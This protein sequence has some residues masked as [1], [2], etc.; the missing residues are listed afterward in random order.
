MNHDD[1]DTPRLRRLIEVGSGLVGNLDLESLL[2][3]I[4][5][6][7]REVT[8][9]RYAALGI[10]G[11]DRQGLDRFITSGIEDDLRERIGSLPRGR[12]VLGV[13][14]ADPRPLRLS[15]VADHPASFGFPEH[16][17]QMTSFL[18]VPIVI[19]GEVYGN[20]Y[21]TDRQAGDFD[22][23]DEASATTLAAWAAIAIANAESVREGRLRTTLEA[24]DR[25]RRRWARELHD[26][27]LQG[28]GGLQVLLSSAARKGDRDSLES[29]TRAA[30]EQISVEIANLRG[31]ISELR[32]A[33]LD[34]IG[35]EPALESLAGRTG[36]TTDFEVELDLS[37]G[38]ARGQ[39]L[40]AELE[41][42]VYRLVQEALTNVIKHA[43]ASHVWVRVA[44]QGKMLELSV[45]DDGVGFEPGTTNGGLGLTGMRERVTLAGGELD[46]YT[47]P[48]S[49]TSVRALLPFSGS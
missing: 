15:R 44:R 28:L 49:G 38:L 7:A 1:L 23:S 36:L 18:G 26:E 30:V 2:L 24:S 31:L 10:L 47:A 12:G 9:A 46:V 48:G 41:S 40:P 17:P 42:S 34:Q 20:L 11:E 33:A 3:Q 13:L 45:R 16:H 29:A 4:V 22:R 6:V 21:L 8:G 43:H 25:E 35:L 14:I 32:P 19:R 39:R 37:L 5:E 27:T